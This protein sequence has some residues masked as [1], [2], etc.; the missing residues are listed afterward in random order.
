VPP[1]IG[2]F[3]D[4]FE[5][6]AQ[7]TRRLTLFDGVVDDDPGRLM[8]M[9]VDALV[10]GDRDFAAATYRRLFH[11]LADEVELGTRPRGDAW[12]SHLVE[13]LL[14]DE[15]PFSRKCEQ[16]GFEATGPALREAAAV[17]LAALQSLHALDAATVIAAIGEPLPSWAELSP[18]AEPDLVDEER[19]V[20][21]LLATSSEWSALVEPL[22]RHY[23]DGGAG[24]LARHRAFRW[25]GGE[26]PIEV[27]RDVDPIRLSDLIGYELERELVVRNTEHFVAGHAANNVLLYG[28]RGTGKSSTVKALLNEYADRGLRL[29]EVPKSLLAD[30][31]QL[32]RELRGRR[33]RFLVFVDDLSFDDHETH[34]KDLKAV[35]EGGVEARP[36]N[37]L[38]Y[39]TS[40]R[41]HLVLERFSDRGGPLD[42]LHA[43]DTRQEKLSFSDRFGIAV[44]FS[45]PDQDRYLQIV[46]GLAQARGIALP[47][48]ELRRRSLEWATWQ[49]GRSARTARQ[50]VDFLA[51]ELGLPPLS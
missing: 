18:R 32:L 10:G 23:H 7:A 30:L 27:V 41:R 39:A 33:E 1:I 11:R 2:G 43:S 46:N 51:G 12:Q 9:V 21:H 6:A 28:D 37:V 34:Y 36:T 47:P 29:V 50:F 15:N 42:E 17:D 40:N 8:G 31:A 16:V 25:V 48:D 4:P 49:N 5:K 44:T 38:L 22:G 20:R 14:A 45:A 35:L 3:V 26:H 19:R 24:L 13:R